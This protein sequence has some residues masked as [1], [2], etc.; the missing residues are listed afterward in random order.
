MTTPGWLAL[1]AGIALL[2]GP[3]AS[4]T[5]L[6]TLSRTGR[7]AERAR[8]DPNGRPDWIARLLRA[9]LFALATAAGCIVVAWAAG[10]LL[11]AAMLASCRVGWL[12][13]RDARG[14][15][16]E[17]TR[18]AQL[19]RAL[20][21]LIGEFEAGARPAAAL[22]AAA[23]SAPAHERVFAAAA[24]V[25]VDG[26]DAADLL[27]AEPDTRPI[28]LA[29]RLG[30]SVGLEVSGALSRVEHDLAARDEQRRT[31]AV[32]LAG[33]RASAVLL[34]GLPLVGLALGAAMGA[35]PWSVLVGTSAGQLL[36]LVGVLFDVGGV[37]WMRRILRGAQRL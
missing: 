19:R 26:D 23:D 30:E 1:A 6:E 4:G 14:R 21:V 37:L 16:V 36:A 10:V 34:A 2:A 33:P 31:V 3:A 28:G 5:R 29:W 20:R 8:A 17:Q 22:A 32:A 12:L 27:A 18:A 13:V 9:R 25:A 7:L 24:R 11:A 35:R 15:Q